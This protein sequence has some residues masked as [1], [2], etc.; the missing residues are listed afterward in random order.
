MSNRKV[1]VGYASG[2]TEGSGFKTRRRSAT[3]VI[4][5][6]NL[7]GG[8]SAQLHVGGKQI[9]VHG[10]VFENTMPWSML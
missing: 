6:R 4:D 7:R 9:R 2:K 8:R 10:E 1:R 5:W 3:Q